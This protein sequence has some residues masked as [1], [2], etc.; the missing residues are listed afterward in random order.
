MRTC[1]A[2]SI[3]ALL[4][5]SPITAA[6]DTPCRAATGTV[7]QETYT[8]SVLQGQ[9]RYSIYLPPCYDQTDSTYPVI[10]LLHG[11]NDDDN[12]WL[13]LGF[14]HTL[15]R[16]ITQG[17]LPPVIVVM[18]YGDTLSNRNEFGEQS[19]PAIFLNDLLPTIE[20]RY[21]V[22][23]DSQRRAIGGIS[24][25]G[26]WAFHIAL[27]HPE[28]FS[29]VGGHSAF[30]DEN[31]APPEFNPLDLALS[32]DIGHLVIWLDRGRDDYAAPGLELMH[33]RL[34]W[35]GIAHE[36]TVY[37]T[38]EHNNGYWASHL[39]DYL[40]FYTRDWTER[41]IVE[42][43]QIDVHSG[44]D[45]YLPVVS[46]PSVQ[47]SIDSNQL[48]AIAVGEW[49]S[50]M[51]LAT[52]VAVSLTSTG[53]LLHPDTR[54]IEPERL[55]DYLWRNRMAYTLLPFDRLNTRYRILYVDRQHPL[56]SDL[57][58]YPFAF[59]SETPN[60]YPDRL[61]T[62]SMSGVTALAR[63][64]RV[65][66]ENNSVQWAGEA[67]RPYVMQADYFHISSEVSFFETC[68]Q[69]TGDLLGGSNS[70]CSDDAHFDLLTFLDVDVIELSGNHNNDYGF[71]AYRRTLTIYNDAQIPTIGGG[72]TLAE[73]RQ[74]L[75]LQHNGSSFAMIACNWIGPYY[76][77]VDDDAG[78]PGAAFCDW[79]WLSETLPVL[80][81][82]NDVLIVTIQY[83]EIDDYIPLDSQRYDFRRIAELGADVVLGTQ[84]HQP[85]T[86]E[87][88]P[89]GDRT[90]F[91]HYGLG[92]LFF[93][94]EFW[95][96]MRFF[97]DTLYIYEGQV[98]TV[99]LFTGIIE[100]RARPRPMTD[101]EREN[102]LLFMFIQKNGF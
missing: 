54:L 24:R 22:D 9:W 26:F 64:T 99:D 68:P 70:M 65:A 85:Q 101:E 82:E 93:D 17:E 60:Y 62:I 84:A 49:D 97:I 83:Q 5:M 71:D 32:A 8:S 58:N 6:Q 10:Y 20:S 1:F 2:I 25:G 21:R 50:N 76:A 19:W 40:A 42:S 14:Q 3:L 41:L 81:V 74:P 72:E 33:E 95:G 39:E 31:H 13:R 46:F 78:R 91:I 35:R 90:A 67:I 102:F 80:A 29:R 57:V 96:N 44:I 47:Y 36:Y 79:D 12:H 69:T 66:I 61:T 4:L 38:G 16:G 7:V 59:P 11:S 23:S 27:R 63:Q 88:Y 55:F 28:L 92:N 56:Q 89:V 77:L 30:F 34:A 18:P 37:P 98:V 52:D 45:L 48:F 87:F 94:Q 51:I 53:I 100:D 86:F 73:A 43:D 15:D 75:I